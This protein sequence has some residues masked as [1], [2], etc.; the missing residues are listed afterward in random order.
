MQGTQSI[1]K[2]PVI[3]VIKEIPDFVAVINNNR[4]VHK[5][6]IRDHE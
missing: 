5:S 1:F 3:N 4:V 2:E 6:I